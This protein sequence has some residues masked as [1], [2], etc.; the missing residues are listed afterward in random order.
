MTQVAK[1]TTTWVIGPVLALDS[2]CTQ[3]LIGSEQI[4]LHFTLQ[5][6]RVFDEC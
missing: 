6:Q 5:G 1:T 3:I 4:F 2:L